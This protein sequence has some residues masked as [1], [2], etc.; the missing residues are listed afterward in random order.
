MSMSMSTSTQV[1]TMISLISMVFALTPHTYHNVTVNDDAEC[2]FSHIF[3]NN[4]YFVDLSTN[5]PVNK[6]SLSA[7]GIFEYGFVITNKTTFNLL[8]GLTCVQNDNQTEQ[9]PKVM[10]VIGAN[11]PAQ[12]NI[13]IFGYYGAKGTYEIVPGVGENYQ[14]I[15]PGVKRHV[16]SSQTRHHL[17]T[18]KQKN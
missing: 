13:N 5:N 16:V 9:S 14:V 11:G 10:F 7:S 1:L 17:H 18:G 15:F 2:Q 4:F 8:Y 6:F 3:E 12:P